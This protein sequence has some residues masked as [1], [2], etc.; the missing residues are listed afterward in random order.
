MAS[1]LTF[2]LLVCLVAAPALA[3]APRPLRDEL[4]AAARRDW[5]AARELYDAGD[6]RSALVHFQRVYTTS[7]NPRALFN[8][9]VCYK[10]LTQY[11]LAIHAWE[12]E[13]AAR[14]HLPAAD[15]AKLTGAIRALRPFVSTLEVQANEAGAVLSIDGYEVGRTPLLEPVPIDVGR[16]RVRLEKADFVPLEQ[17]LDVAQ[18]TPVSVSFELSPVLQR[19]ALSVTLSGPAR[20]TLVM[21]G[22]EIGVAPFQGE[23]AVGPHTFELRA[24]GFEPARQTTEVV[25]GR[26]SRLSFALVE[27]RNDGKLSITTAH[28]TAEIRVDG[29]LQGYGRWQGLVPA[30]GHRLEVTLAGYERHAAEVSLSRNQE[31]Q[32]EV[33]LE[34]RQSWVWWAVGLGAIVGG[35]AV[36]TALLVRSS[37][38]P[39]VNGTLPPG[40]VSF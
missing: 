28:A 23:V 26:P 31:R 19:A 39:A 15:V 40:L 17:T 18:N 36:A 32:L 7:Q 38:S 34:K 14:E 35:G 11:A 25:Y 37:D 5:D 16:R 12:R 13:L 22:R 24:P 33:Q 29:V 2:S 9:G 27:Q 21:D 30:G 20:G 10:D 8:I 6:Y 1:W 4:P 3:E